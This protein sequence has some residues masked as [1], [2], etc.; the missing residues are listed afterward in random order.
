MLGVDEVPYPSARWTIEQT[1]A[2]DKYLQLVKQKKQRTIT[3]I[4]YYSPKAPLHINCS[5]YRS[6]QLQEKEPQQNSNLVYKERSKEQTNNR[7]GSCGKKEAENRLLCSGG[8]VRFG[9]EA[10]EELA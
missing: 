8:L 6:R 4:E 3:R 1:S 2:R 10:I 5:K 7:W 9:G